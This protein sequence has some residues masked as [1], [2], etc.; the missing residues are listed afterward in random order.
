MYV[1]AHV[2][3]SIM[4]HISVVMKTLFVFSIISLNLFSFF[5]FK[6]V[7]LQKLFTYYGKITFLK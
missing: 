7:V 4:C 2:L 1:H 6:V 3:I 5:F